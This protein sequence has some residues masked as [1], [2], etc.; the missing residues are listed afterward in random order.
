MFGGFAIANGINP[1]AGFP[2]VTVR[3][4]VCN[5][6]V[7]K[8]AATNVAQAYTR[9]RK[10]IRPKEDFHLGGQDGKQLSGGSGSSEEK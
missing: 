7:P 2:I 4:T 8:T 1:E 9:G 5:W 10:R 3:V 6:V